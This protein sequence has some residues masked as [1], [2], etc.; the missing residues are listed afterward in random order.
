MGLLDR[1]RGEESGVCKFY[2]DPDDVV[3]TVSTDTHVIAYA[4]AISDAECRALRELLEADDAAGDREASLTQAIGGALDDEAADPERIA[5]RVNR[6]RHVAEGL[7]TH[8][9]SLLDDDPDVVYLPL[10]AVGE[11]AAYVETVRARDE[12]EEDA[13]A[14][15][16]SF[17]T[18]AS[19]LVRLNE[20]TDRAENR[21]VVHR[22]RLPSPDGHSTDESP[23]SEANS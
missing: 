18:V 4:V 3:F 5:A 10:G 16:E 8:W 6:P 23:S 1:L 7:C 9:E 13:F 14:L 12:R 11:L 21:V 20:T 19:L 22:D 2:Y 17:E 15:P